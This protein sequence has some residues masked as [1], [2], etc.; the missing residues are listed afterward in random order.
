M[1]LFLSV[2]LAQ[3][4]DSAKEARLKKQEEEEAERKMINEASHVSAIDVE[5]TLAGV[6][7]ITS[8]SIGK[9]HF[10]YHCLRFFIYLFCR[11]CPYDG[12]NG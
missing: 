5:S 4:S 11:I 7:G 9:C 8:P 10:F 12:G 2:L 1:N 3:F 6:G